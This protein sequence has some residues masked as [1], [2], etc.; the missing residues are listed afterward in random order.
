MTYSP[1]RMLLV[2][3]ASVSATLD[4]A[5]YRSM[6]M[7]VFAVSSPDSVMALAREK[8][9]EMIVLNFDFLGEETA[10]L[11]ESLRADEDFHLIPL[12]VTSVQ[13]DAGLKKKLLAK[14]VNLF[15]EQPIPRPYFVEQL[16]KLLTRM[17]RGEDRI[18]AQ[19]GDS[20][21]VTI[22]GQKYPAMIGDLSS[23]G[24]F[25]CPQGD[26]IPFSEGDHCSVLISM[27]GMTQACQA[28]CEVVRI[29]HHDS[30]FPDR[31]AGAGLIF[32]AFE[33]DGEKVLMDFLAVHGRAE[34]DQRMLYYL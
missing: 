12:V 21:H 9:A 13:G 28:E 18:H 25:L 5:G 1:I 17:I 31:Q 26:D 6:G 2:D 22:H 27:A 34:E 10:R 30:R 19:E 8:K 23:S 32:R 7:Q 33:K 16:K 29:L 20:V 14:G 4:R 3:D 11:C 24:L 15:V